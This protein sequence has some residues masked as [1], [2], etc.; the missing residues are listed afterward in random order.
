MAINK[1]YNNILSEL[2]DVA[3]NLKTKFEKEL[4]VKGNIAYSEIAA[5]SIYGSD[6]DKKTKFGKTG[7]S[8]S[9]SMLMNS[10]KSNN[11]RLTSKERARSIE[12]Y[13]KIIDQAVSELAADI[14][15]RS[16]KVVNHIKSNTTKEQDRERWAN[17][18]GFKHLEYDDGS[19]YTHD[20]IKKTLEE[21]I[22]EYIDDDVDVD[23]MLNPNGTLE[24][25]RY[26]V[27]E[28]LSDENNV[29]HNY[30]SWDLSES[31]IRE[32]LVKNDYGR[33]TSDFIVDDTMNELIRIST[34]SDEQYTE[35][36]NNST[37]QITNK[38]KEKSD[39]ERLMNPGLRNETDSLVYEERFNK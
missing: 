7:N 36:K 5:T 1:D 19:K 6:S 27:L 9:E 14:S 8:V 15:G 4:K 17:K 18:E 16:K 33:Y 38:L 32:E 10:H 24:D 23:H 26:S 25:L 2:K 11:N 30:E 39:L 22:T 31:F 28:K 21:Y 29:G 12:N 37:S 35:Y 20:D 13:K 3:S 34:L